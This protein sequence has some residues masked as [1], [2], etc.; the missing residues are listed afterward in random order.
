M[1]TLSIPRLQNA[2]TL[3]EKRIR[4]HKPSITRP[5]LE[6]RLR[7]QP[8]QRPV[9][10][11]PHLPLPREDR[12]GQSP[13]ARVAHQHEILYGVEE[14]VPGTLAAREAQ[15]LEL[16]QVRVGFRGADGVV[17]DGVLG[18]EFVG[19]VVGAVGHVDGVAVGGDD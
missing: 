12:Q 8:R 15:T 16:E 5:I 6:P 10:E 4:I 18:V 19:G 9:P 2:P 11:S 7:R 17:G 3:L 13:H 14:R 1:C